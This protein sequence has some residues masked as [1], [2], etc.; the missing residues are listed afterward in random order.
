M[1]LVALHIAA[2]HGTSMHRSTEWFSRQPPR[3]AIARSVPV[4]RPNGE[5]SAV[6]LVARPL[7]DPRGWRWSV[8]DKGT[9]APSRL[10]RLLGARAAG[11]RIRSG[12]RAFAE[13]RRRRGVREQGRQPAGRRGVPQG[14]QGG[15]P[16][17]ERGLVPAALFRGGE[18]R[19]RAAAAQLAP[20]AARVGRDLG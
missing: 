2:S 16:G 10:F 11:G 17:Q 1:F 18:G 3:N 7:R 4:V 8:C 12:R 20:C 15:G 13:L 9:G 6:A 19:R 14:K 5:G